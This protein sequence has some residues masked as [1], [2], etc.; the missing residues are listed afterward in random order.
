MW[1]V[2]PVGLKCAQTSCLTDNIEGCWLQGIMFPSLS[3][4][5]T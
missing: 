3:L 1:L 5:K 4:L 2:T